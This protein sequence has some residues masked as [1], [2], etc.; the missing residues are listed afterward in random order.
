VVLKATTTAEAANIRKDERPEAMER[1]SRK[2][3]EAKAEPTF[4][5]H[6]AGPEPPG[7]GTAKGARN[8]SDAGKGTRIGS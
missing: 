3:R 1:V 4:P 2:K 7:K 8:G 5:D 6:P